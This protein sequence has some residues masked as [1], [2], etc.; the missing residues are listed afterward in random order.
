MIA[1]HLA[2]GPIDRPGGVGGVDDLANVF[3]ESKQGDHSGP[4]C[5]PGL[6]DGWIE[7]I[8]FLEPSA[9]D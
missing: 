3:W 6:A 9:P 4:V 5:P 7:R 8:P 2:Q 1:Y